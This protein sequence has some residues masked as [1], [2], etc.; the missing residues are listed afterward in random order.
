MKKINKLVSFALSLI[1]VSMTSVSVFSACAEEFAADTTTAVLDIQQETFTTTSAPSEDILTPS[2]NGV[3]PELV[4]GYKIDFG[5][6]IGDAEFIDIYL[7]NVSDIVS[8]YGKILFDVTVDGTV[9]TVRYPWNFEYVESPCLRINIPD[10]INANVVW[11]ETCMCY[12]SDMDS[13]IAE[14][15]M[16]EIKN[17]T[18]AT[19]SIL[20]TRDKSQD[21]PVVTESAVDYPEYTYTYTRPAE[22][23]VTTTMPVDNYPEY[24]YTYTYTIPPETIPENLTAVKKGDINFNGVVDISDV[25]AAASYAGNPEQNPLSPESITNGDVHNIGDGITASDVLMIQQYISCII[26]KL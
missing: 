23:V 2:I 26:K 1:M 16:Q 13:D 22:I 19:L 12:L 11:N 21:M 5:S 18:Y 10:T 9:Y 7:Q 4:D 14:K 17:C 3:V 6:P 8:A 15:I 20:Y 25:V 24:T